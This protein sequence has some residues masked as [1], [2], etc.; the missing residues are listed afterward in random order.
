MKLHP[1][2][3]DQSCVFLITD[4]KTVWA[5]VLSKQQLSR[6]WSMLKYNST[7]SHLPHPNE[8]AWLDQVLQYLVDA[9]T[10]RMMGDLSFEVI[11]S[12]YSVTG[13]AFGA[14]FQALTGHFRIWPYTFVERGSNGDGR[15]FPSDPSSRQRCFR[16]TS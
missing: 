6:R 3:A 7:P 16:S 4:T 11:D 12:R 2:F 5:E 8:D 15:P 1:T 14:T 10:P 13:W 9:H